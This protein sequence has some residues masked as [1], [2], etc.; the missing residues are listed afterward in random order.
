MNRSRKIQMLTGLVFALSFTS[1]AQAKDEVPYK[2]RVLGQFQPAGVDDDGN[3][4]LDFH[5][6]GQATELGRFV[7]MGQ[8]YVADDLTFTGINTLTAANGDQIDLNIKDGLLTETDTDGI[9]VIELETEFTGGS[10]RFENVTGGFSG[11][12]ELNMTEGFFEGVGD[13][14]MSPPGKNKK[15]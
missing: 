8:L 4:I 9:F 5:T 2:D 14:T 11:I 3:L 7:S 10:G 15:K 13:G 12:G 6:V 1:A